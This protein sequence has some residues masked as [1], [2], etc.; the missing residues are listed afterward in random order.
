MFILPA[1]LIFSRG[2]ADTTAVIIS[3]CFI[4]HSI[5][6]RSW[7]WLKKPWVMA[8]LALWG[9]SILIV[10]P[11]ATDPWASAWEAL[12]FIRFIIFGAA[13][14]Y[15]ILDDKYNM[16]LFQ[17]GMI[18]VVIFIVCDTF[19]QFK[20]GEDIFGHQMRLDGRLAGPF[21]GLVVGTILTRISFISIAAI[22]F[23]S[24]TESISKK[25]LITSISISILLWCIFITGE[26]GAFLS[27]SMCTILFLLTFFFTY[28]KY[29]AMVMSSAIIFIMLIAGIAITNSKIKSRMIDSTIT[30]VSD[31]PNT[32]S[33]RIICSAFE[34][35]SKNGNYFT[36]IGVRNYRLQ[37]VHKDNEEIRKK[38]NLTTPPHT[39]N[40]YIE[41]LIEAGIIGFI[42]FSLMI[43]L[44]LKEI[45]STTL[46][47]RQYIAAT[48]AFAVL[49]TTFFPFM[50][51]MSFFSNHIALIIWMTVGWSIAFTSKKSCLERHV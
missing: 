18:A 24:K 12:I 22:W 6:N 7:R 25:F 49:L 26:R 2:V 50:G 21:S 33:A 5:S 32:D 20:T 36:G 10:S 34:I 23:C 11:L 15:W 9:F 47:Q 48:F 40:I 13:L 4:S 42:C 37:I 1:L 28:K 46:P 8:A 43:C 27:Y 45:F 16:R 35:W 44:I 3:A 31:Y 19:Y 51:A 38:Y 39:H 29:R 30:F 17:N 14:A 41:W